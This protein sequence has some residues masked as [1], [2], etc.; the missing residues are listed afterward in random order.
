M[1]F[2]PFYTNEN[3]TL[4]SPDSSTVVENASIDTVI[5]DAEANDPDN[6][7]L[8]Y[9]VSGSDASYVTIDSDDGEIRLIS[10]ADYETK[11]SYTFDVT[12]SDDELSDTKSVTVNVTDVEEYEGPLQIDLIGSGYDPIRDQNFIELQANGNFGDNSNIM[13]GFHNPLVGSPSDGT[14]MSSIFSS[15][16]IYLLINSLLIGDP[17]YSIGVYF[18]FLAGGIKLIS[19]LYAKNSNNYVK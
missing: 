19:I 18:V 15:S 8:T 5:Y 16:I 17:R 11:D 14:G 9:S 7:T 2:N 3:P 1:G 12:A 13:L 10:P 6:D 4:T